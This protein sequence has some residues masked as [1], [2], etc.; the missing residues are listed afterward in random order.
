MADRRKKRSHHGKEYAGLQDPGFDWQQGGPPAESE[1]SLSSM[2]H[3]ARWQAGILDVT[4]KLIQTPSDR[5]DDGI[6]EALSSTG[7]LAGS[8]RTYVFR[9][10]AP[11]R[12]DNTHEWCADGI[13]PMIHLLQDMPDSLLDEW[14]ENFRRDAAVYIPDVM[15]L[16]DASA[17]REVLAMQGIQSLLAVPMLRD[18]RL[19]GFVGYDAVRD[20][21]QFSPIE[22]QLIQSVANAIGVMIDRA[23]A[24]AAATSARAS[25]RD[26]RDRLK[27]TLSALPDLVLELGPDC[28]FKEYNS[29][30]G[31]H[32]AFRPDEFIGKLPEDVLP[33]ALAADLREMLRNVDQMGMALPVEYEL[34]IDGR[35]QWFHAR[36]AS[37]SLDGQHSGYIVAIRDISERMLRELQIMRLAKVAERT[38]NLVVVT[39]TAARIE[40]V[41]PAF[42]TRSGW[43]LDAVRG[44]KPFPLLVARSAP[45][46]LQDA[47]VRAFERGEPL[48]AE[49]PSQ[50]RAGDKYW[51]SL[52]IQPLRDLD[53]NLIGFVSV[54]TDITQLKRSQLRALRERAAAMD[55]SSDGIAICDVNGPYDYMNRAHREMFGIGPDEDI[56]ELTWRDL[57]PADTVKSFMDSSFKQ[58]MLTRAW[59]GELMGVA[60]DGSVVAQEVTLTLK[61]NDKLLCI[62]RDKT[63]KLRAE[64]E[65]ARLREE[66]Q[67]AQRR[68]TIAHISAGV[69][70]DL[71]NLVAVI[72]GTA[73]LLID[74]T[75]EDPELASGIRRIM[76]ATDAAQ[77]LVA[78]L[79]KL[80][81]PVARRERLDLRS[82]VSE[83]VELLGSDRLHRH[84]ITVSA[85]PRECPVWA[86]TTDVLQVIVNLALNACESGKNTVPR[87]SITLCP[88]SHTLPKRA[89]DVG[90]LP[91][92]TSISVVAIADTG[93]GIDPE[94]REHLFERYFTTKGAAGTGLGL[95]I[96]TGILR[97]NDAAMWVESTPGKG[98][99]MFVAWP[100]SAAKVENPELRDRGLVELVDLARHN[101]LVVDDVADVADVAD[102]VASMLEAAGAVV[103]SMSDPIEARTL[104]K[105]NPGVWSALVTDLHM[106]KLDG[107]E[108]AKVAATLDPPVPT[109]LVT[110]LANSVGKDA[111]FFTEVLAKPVVA[112][113]LLEA[114]RAAASGA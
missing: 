86:N 34:E 17:V 32:P 9:T 111:R 3:Y 85:P 15:A 42:S 89:P 80:G 99:T 74:R 60:R 54:A 97:D 2:V 20:H 56:R 87:V 84:Q 13:D 110:A 75:Q 70:H 90:I 28:R 73:N 71:N 57:Y 92:D 43:A 68:E 18:G 27:A 55:V 69:A 29:G 48:Q 41:N 98:T 58:L 105:E 40:W 91:P 95:P 100:T 93:S 39:D 65:Q 30:S 37:M 16:P 1:K 51:I 109:V 19:T 24:E 103:I 10:R 49:V 114:V 47:V 82:L 35:R 59:R 36:A 6:N 25:L 63:E 21:R 107:V 106:P 64:A 83:G 33:P 38:S 101:I 23:A 50:T 113:Q 8:D 12:L 112:E 61:D 11:D 81:R 7:Q 26:E 94:T 5:I 14:R 77:D 78:G 88:D 66:L 76:R 31:L 67:S 46:H 62:T 53:D 108:L 52:D 96:V 72:S 104:L 4:N 44:E 79:G 22:I 102:V 45:R